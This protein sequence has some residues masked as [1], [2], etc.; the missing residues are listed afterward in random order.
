[1]PRLPTLTRLLFFLVG[2]LLACGAIAFLGPRLLHTMNPAHLAVAED[3]IG[4]IWWP[5]TVVRLLVYVLLALG[6]YPAW[7]RMRR[8]AW[9]SAQSS[10]A[11]TEMVE[12]IAA[13][14]TPETTE[15][16]EVTPAD[17]AAQAA[18]VQGR[19]HFD[20]AAQRQ[21]VVFGGLLLSDLLL[22]QFPYWLL[23]G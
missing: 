5:A 16:P 2:L 4:Q 17:A 19:A 6:V 7:V 20:R 9:E 11:A 1:M 15:M 12:G 23:R 22:V 18:V 8:A 13:T 3:V 21:A 10:W 14:E